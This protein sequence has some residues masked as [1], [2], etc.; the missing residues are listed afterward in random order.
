M[1][2]HTGFEDDDRYDRMRRFGWMD[3]DRIQSVRCMVVGAGALGNEVVKDMV[4]AGFKRISV[5][6]MDGIV[7]SNLSRCL[8]FRGTDVKVS[9]KADIVAKRGMVLDPSCEITPIRSRIED[10]TDWDYDLIIGC[11]DNIKARM[12]INAYACYRGI[13]FIDGAM[14][15]LM[16]KVQVILPEGP[17]LECTLNRTHVRLMETRFTCTGNGEAFVPKIASDITTAAV[18]A[19]M[20]VREALKLVSGMQGSCIHDILYYD[21]MSGD[22]VI[23]TVPI[24]ASCPN[25]GCIHESGNNGEECGEQFHGQDGGRVR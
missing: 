25:H 18:I 17:C 1:M 12:H 10:V 5:V 20:Q 4:L 15:G 7:T 23:C 2:I 6:D 13:P 22:V 21:G 3:M 8:F 19:A 14:D 9:D 11:V 16:G 24:S